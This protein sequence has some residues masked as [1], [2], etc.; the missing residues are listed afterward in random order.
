[1]MVHLNT[2][3]L[4]YTAA[5]NSNTERVWHRKDAGRPEDRHS[6]LWSHPLALHEYTISSTIVCGST[7]SNAN[8]ATGTRRDARSF[9]AA[10]N[11]DKRH[12][13]LNQAAEHADEE[14]TDPQKTETA[15]S[16]VSERPGEGGHEGHVDMTSA[17]RTVAAMPRT[18][19][20]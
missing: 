16:L 2:V 7:A 14:G 1:M 4:A 9:A 5:G 13:K 10:E 20:M 19:S 12:Q 3:R 15:P 8:T 11:F 18:M 6:H 17:G